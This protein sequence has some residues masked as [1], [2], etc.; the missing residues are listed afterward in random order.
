L[1]ALLATPDRT[2]L[3]GTGPI[4]AYREQYPATYYRADAALSLQALVLR[5]ERARVVAANRQP[6]IPVP[7]RRQMLPAEALAIE[8]IGHDYYL[9]DRPGGKD[10]TALVAFLLALDD[11]PGAP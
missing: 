9:D 2:K 3:Y 5:S 11:E 4:L 7:G 1:A 10:V 6:V 8:G